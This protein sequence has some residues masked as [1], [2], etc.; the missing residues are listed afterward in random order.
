[1]DAHDFHRT[2]TL[3]DPL[4]Q[5]GDPG[6]SSILFFFSSVASQSSFLSAIY[7]G[8]RC[9]E[10]IKKDIDMLYNIIIDRMLEHNEVLH[11]LVNSLDAIAM[12]EGGTAIIDQYA[13]ASELIRSL[14]VEVGKFSGGSEA[15]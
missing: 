13:E 5:S 8:L 3:L 10:H 11:S 1:M 9:A 12:C 15:E 6:K 2:A 14:I 4:V 7:D